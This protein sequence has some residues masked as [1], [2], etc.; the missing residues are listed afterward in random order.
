[1]HLKKLNYDL[2]PSYDIVICGGGGAGLW[3]LNILKSLGYSVLL[4]ENHKVG[5]IQTIA[6]QGMIHGGQRYMLGKIPSIHAESVSLLPARWDSCL[7]GSGEIDLRKVKILSNTQVMW[8][9]ANGLSYFALNTASYLIKAKTRK[10]T[11]QE[12]PAAL[13]KSNAPIYE[14][15]EKV[16]DVASLVDVLSASHHKTIFIGSVDSLSRDGTLVVSGKKIIA[17]LVICVAGLGNERF[18]SLL[19][20]GTKTSQRRPLRQLM[21]RTLP[22]PLYG[23]G[24]TTSYKPRVTITSHPLPFGGYV[25]YLGG[26][27]ADT[28]SLSN[29][30]AIS[31]AKQEMNQI[32]PY[33]DWAD[34]EWATWYGYRAEPYC[35]DGQLP[36]GPVIHEYGNVLVAWPT[37]LTLIPLLGDKILNLLKHKRIM[38]TYK[39]AD[40]H[41]HSAATDL[42]II[43]PPWDTAEWT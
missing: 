30:K 36:D 25:W 41:H 40:S 15:P 7:E 6:S 21:V 26:A 14:L 35:K 3:L 19:E 38:P 1:M 29:D 24:I 10:L 28:L 9:T 43:L 22:F 8:P 23:H 4:V 16:L 27:I 11:A 31:F 33:Y 37:K 2:M 12:I 13:S 34:M 20:A 18:L 5:G 17:E 42:P 32:F 39:P